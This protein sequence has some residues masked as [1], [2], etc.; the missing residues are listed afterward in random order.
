[1]RAILSVLLLFTICAGCNSVQLADMSPAVEDSLQEEMCTPEQILEHEVQGEENL[2]SI[3]DKYG[4]TAETVL[5]A[6]YDE[7]ADNPNNLI[8]KTDKSCT[9]ATWQNE[10]FT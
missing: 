7:L 6:N 9:I 2:F 1:M 5:W 4:L 3:A 8:D 10:S